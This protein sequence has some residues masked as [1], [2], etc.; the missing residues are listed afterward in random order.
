MT[1][2]FALSAGTLLAFA[3]VSTTATVHHASEAPAIL[4]AIPFPTAMAVAVAQDAPSTPLNAPPT[5]TLLRWFNSG[6]LGR[7]QWSFHDV[8]SV[9]WAQAARAAAELCDIQGIGAGH[10]NGHQ[11]L[12]KRTFGVQCSDAEVVWREASAQE[13]ASSGWGFSDV[14]QVS[15]AQANRAAERL[16]AGANQGFAGGYFNGHQGSGNYGLFCYRGEAKWFD[17]SDAELAATGWG[18]A[19][20]LLDDVQWAQAMRAATGFCQGKGFDGGFMNGHQVPNKYGVVCQK[21]SA[22]VPAEN[23]APAPSA[24]GASDAVPAAT[25][26][27][28][29][30]VTLRFTDD[31]CPF[32]DY[33]ETRR[34]EITPFRQSGFF[35][36][37][38]AFGTFFD[39]AVTLQGPANVAKTGGGLFYSGSVQVNLPVMPNEV[40]AEFTGIITSDLSQFNLR[41][42]INGTCRISGV[43][44][45]RRL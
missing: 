45:G 29:Y 1:S 33:R 12:N 31:T 43:M 35:L 10:F 36:P 20:P 5:T 26:A 4:A 34:A 24:P 17:A 37:L 3:P 27:S 32:K 11:D 42:E 28:R 16:C 19:T 15:W 40:P 18:F 23:P 41:F 6:D 22:V 7:T 14:N 13:I 2:Y 30:G 9:G 21:A 8:N 25:R 38:H 44:E 39:G